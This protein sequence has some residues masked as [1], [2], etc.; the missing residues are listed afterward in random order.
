MDRRS[1]F[2]RLA[3]AV[4]FALS[5]ALATPAAAQGKSEDKV[6]FEIMPYLWAAGISG[7]I[8]VG[9]IATGGV[10]A[11]F[12][13]LLDDLDMALMGMIE[14]RYGRWG[15][16]LDGIYMDLSKNA[17]TR[18]LQGK[19]EVKF[20]QQ[21]Y[22]LAPTYRVLDEE[23]FVDALAGVRY[24]YVKT[25]LTIQPGQHP[26]VAGGRQVSASDNWW[27]GFVGARIA[28][29]LPFYKPIA[30]V[31]YVDLGAMDGNFMWQGIA[32]ANWQI[33]EMFS[34]K[35]GYRYLSYDVGAGIN[36]FDLDTGGFYAGLGIKF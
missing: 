1:A 24:L 3:A 34:A 27:G 11:S 26:L 6:S 29:P 4:V 2:R 5:V 15:L 16:L 23:V 30:L 22:S 31:G 7:N 9:T 10:D 20:E 13:D 17:D 8:S 28:W 33:S 36:E 21:L 12:S 25:Q 19:S 32:G 35:L 14:A 18:D